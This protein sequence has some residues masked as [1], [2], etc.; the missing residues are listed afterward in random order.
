MN[1][2]ADEQLHA[3]ALAALEQADMALAHAPDLNIDEPHRAEDITPASLT[4]MLAGSVPGAMVE[5]IDLADAH[6]GMTTRNKWNVR[7]NGAGAAAG[8][9]AQ[10]FVKVTPE[11][12]Y[13][14]ET[15]A[16]LHMAEHEVR[17]YNQIQP[18]LPDIA[19]RAYYARS[20][21]G[22]RFL[23]LMEVLEARGL[24]PYWQAY[25]CSLDH[26]KAVV[27]VLAKLH[28][29]YWES[30]RFNT[31]LTWVR[32]RTR[33]F[34]FEWHQRSFNGARKQFLE[35]DIGAAQPKE[36]IELIRFWD[37]N[38]R[39]I[40]AYWDSLPM[41]LLH[42][43]S[44]LGNTFSYPDGRAGFFDWQVVYRG[45][46][47]REVAY[48]FLGAAP[49]SMRKQHERE[50]VDF[51]LDNLEANGVAIDREAAWLNYCLFTLDALDAT[52]KTI[53]RG[54]YGH[55]ASAL[56]RGLANKTSSILENGVPELLRKVV[57]DRKL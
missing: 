31:D 3:H 36:I 1:H 11:G 16:M 27:A 44:H 57:R 28:A 19:P 20:Y 7:W 24:K 53:V 49:E 54:G 29:T 15:L 18:E 56:Q 45:Y 17:F 21:P 12:P 48:F 10:V 52:I 50:I 4:R 35:S 42:G 51:Y 23:I 8:L 39:Q 38:D 25:E 47:L 26:A 5:S 32:P 22:G 30:E 6:D 13:L 55:A 46:G 33:R 43:D 34:G 2:K 41:T 9:P 14:R 37:G 40:Y